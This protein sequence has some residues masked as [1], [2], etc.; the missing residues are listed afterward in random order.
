MWYSGEYD[1][2]RIAKW[3]ASVLEPVYALSLLVLTRMPIAT[4]GIVPSIIFST[5]DP[6]FKFALQPKSFSILQGS[7]AE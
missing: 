1:H 6:R 4:Q 2:C 5:I 7:I 3:H